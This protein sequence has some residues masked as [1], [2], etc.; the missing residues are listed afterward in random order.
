MVF[1]SF[2]MFFFFRLNSSISITETPTNMKY[3]IH[4]LL[5]ACAQ[6]CFIFVNPYT[7]CVT[8]RYQHKQCI[9]ME[10]ETETN[11]KICMYQRV[12]PY[13][14]YKVFCVTFGPMQKLKFPFSLSYSTL[15]FT[16]TNIKVK[17]A[18]DIKKQIKIIS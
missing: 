15:N 8:D 18:N 13:S 14:L 10:T 12:L 5:V 4:I 16:F 1:H 3:F 11:M 17:K 6:S 9:I 2:A 7:S